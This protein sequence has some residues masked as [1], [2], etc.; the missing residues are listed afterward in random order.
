LRATDANKLQEAKRTGKPLL[1]MTTYEGN[2][3]LAGMLGYAGIEFLFIDNEHTPNDWKTLANVMRSC[4]LSGIFPM[5][6]V[7]KEYPGYPSNVRMAFEIGAGMVLVPHVN[8]RDEALAVVRAAKFNPKY[9]SGP[10]PADQMRGIDRNTRA[11]RF[12]AVEPP[13]EYCKLEDE[14]RMVALLLEEPRAV[15]NLEERAR[16][17]G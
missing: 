12:V 1:G 4:E 15:E 14:K 9:K 16:I 6:R 7:K 8:T 11:G 13:A 3:D 10:A 17:P 2:P 5:L